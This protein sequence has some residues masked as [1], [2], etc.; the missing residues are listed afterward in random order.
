MTKI[1]PCMADLLCFSFPFFVDF[2]YVFCV[3][4]VYIKLQ[5]YCI[6]ELLANCQKYILNLIRSLQKRSTKAKAEWEE[7]KD[8]LGGENCF[9]FPDNPW[10][11]ERQ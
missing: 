10:K 8:M 1:A 4:L 11:N 6:V 5:F 9:K 2:F 3:K 7:Y